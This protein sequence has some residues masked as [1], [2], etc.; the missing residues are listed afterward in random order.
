MWL[1]ISVSTAIICNVITHNLKP[2]AKYYLENNKKAVLPFNSHLVDSSENSLWGRIFSFCEHP[3][4]VPAKLHSV[5]SF[6]LYLE[7]GL[8]ILPKQTSN[9]LSS[10]LNFPRS[11][12]Y[13]CALYF[14][15]PCFLP[16]NLVINCVTLHCY[17]WM[18]S[19]KLLARLKIHF[20]ST[21]GL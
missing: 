6:S 11:W 1:S 18:S 12:N 21:L 19:L 5:Y 7:T 8:A 16:H 15:C 2:E 10:Y 3:S 13:R 14:T 20:P 4:L 17:C 9:D